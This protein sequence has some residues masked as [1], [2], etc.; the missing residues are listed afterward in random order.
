M[1]SGTA[2]TPSRELAVDPYITRDDSYAACGDSYTTRIAF[3]V[4]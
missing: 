4:P 1:T 2:I 3:G